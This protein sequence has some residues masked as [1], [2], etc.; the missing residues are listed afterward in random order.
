M[1]TLQRG[2]LSL[3]LAGYLAAHREELA[4]LESVCS[5]NV[6]RCRAVLNSI[7]QYLP[8]LAS[9]GWAGKSGETLNV[10]RH[11]WEKRDNSSHP[12]PTHWRSSVLCRGISIMI[13]SGSWPQR[14]YVAAPSLNREYTPLT[15]LRVVLNY[16]E[17]GFRWRTQR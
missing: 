9:A 17:A 1:P 16:K 8:A 13:T 14:W 2:A 4:Q 6:I 15:L 11:Q 5:G 10:S 7:S 12:T 3:K